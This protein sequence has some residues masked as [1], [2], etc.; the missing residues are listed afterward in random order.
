MEG[1]DGF[2]DLGG[3]GGDCLG[4]CFGWEVVVVGWFYVGYWGVHSCSNFLVSIMHFRYDRYFV[5]G[6]WFGLVGGSN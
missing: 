2:L 4:G 3:F 5:V 6:G 1:F